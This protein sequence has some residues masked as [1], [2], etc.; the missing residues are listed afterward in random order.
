M[1][2]GKLKTFFVGALF[3]LGLIGVVALWIHTSMEYRQARRELIYVKARNLAAQQK[4][5]EWQNYQRRQKERRL[6]EQYQTGGLVGPS[7]QPARTQTAPARPAAK[8]AAK[9]SA[10]GAKKGT[11]A[12]AR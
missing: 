8:P 6:R 11:A 1:A 4:R 9:P 7:A 12:S 2:Q 5:E 3:W 10:S